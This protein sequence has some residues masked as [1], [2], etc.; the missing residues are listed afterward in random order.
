[1]DT[2]AD[3]LAGLV[4]ALD[5]KDAIHVGH[6]TG[7]ASGPCSL[8]GAFSLGLRWED[9][10]GEG[11]VQLRTEWCTQQ[12]RCPALSSRPPEIWPLR[13]E[14]APDGRKRKKSFA[15]ISG[16]RQVAKR[17]LLESAGS[18]PDR[19]MHE[20]TRALEAYLGE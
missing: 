3:D 20:L 8:L 4:A 2:Y 17:R 10:P 14:L 7:E 5:L 16:I 11:R 15:V 6:S 9:A 1:M 12:R 19:F 18:A 13:L